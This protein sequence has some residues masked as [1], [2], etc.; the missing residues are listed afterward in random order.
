[1]AKKPKKAIKAVSSDPDEILG[2]WLDSLGEGLDDKKLHKDIAKEFTQPLLDQIQQML[3]DGNV[4]GKDEEKNTRQVAKD[5]GK[6]CRMLTT[7]SDTI[8]KDKFAAVFRVVRTFHD[9]CPPRGGGTGGWCEL[10]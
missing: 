7:K 10:P 8:S 9:V 3:D 1:M 5:T 2:F 4:F 6:I